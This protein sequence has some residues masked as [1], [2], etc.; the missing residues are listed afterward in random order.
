MNWKSF[1]RRSIAL[2]LAVV[3]L[4][5]VVL[6]GGASASAD[7]LSATL[8][9]HRNLVLALVQSELS[10]LGRLPSEGALHTADFNFWQRLVIDQSSLLR[11]GLP[12]APD[13]PVEGNPPSAPL[14]QAPLQ[15][16]PADQLDPEDPAEE[17]P[18]IPG[19]GETI[20]PRQILPSAGQEQ[21]GGVYLFNRTSKKVDM[22]SIM[23]AA[24]PV[25]ITGGDEPQVL[26]VHTHGSEAYQP[27]SGQS[28]EPSDPYR[29]LDNEHNITR[30]GA[31]VKTVLEGLGVSVLHD[32]TLH[33]YPNYNG[34]YTRSAE[35][36]RQYLNEYPS[37][38]IV[39]DIHRDALIG[40]DGT[41]YK[42]LTVV[43]G[44]D[45]AQVLLIVGTDE[46]GQQHD[47]WV[48]NLVFAGKVQSAM[49]LLYPTLARPVTLRTSRFNQQYRVGSLLVE[50]GSH[51]NTL[52]ESLAA[53]RHFAR[54][55]GLVLLQNKAP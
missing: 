17:I 55:L 54:S 20:V 12:S 15:S 46:G 40:E 28:Y 44:E 13:E 35:T 45:V 32:R 47:N 18:V 24:C 43:D 6:T 38:Q 11:T 33:D 5:L 41:V 52:E 1:L 26:I 42:P 23:A 48:Q 31:E 22:P 37:I 29:T 8:G 30:I 14:E 16:F 39:L 51:G 25:T 34:S 49:N 53:A 21:A 3:A 27:T 4:Y 10:A 19:E 9:A 50:M 2:S 36:I 7:A